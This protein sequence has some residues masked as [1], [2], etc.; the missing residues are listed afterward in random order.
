VLVLVFSSSQL[1]IDVEN[2][3]EVVCCRGSP[4]SAGSLFLLSAL[5]LILII[6]CHN[7]MRYLSAVCSCLILTRDNSMSFVRHPQL[8]SGG[9][10]GIAKYRESNWSQ[11][12]LLQLFDGPWRSGPSPDC[13]Y[14]QVDSKSTWGVKALDMALQVELKLDHVLRN[15]NGLFGVAGTW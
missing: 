12:R 4:I 5:F 6:L 10:C 14:G 13:N 8:C 9:F 1:V 7:H 15:S 3:V 2:I 11:S